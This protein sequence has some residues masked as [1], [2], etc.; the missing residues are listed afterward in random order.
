[1]GDLCD[2]IE[3]DAALGDLSKS[4]RLRGFLGRIMSAAQIDQQSDDL[5]ER[6]A[7][8]IAEVE[9]RVRLADKARWHFRVPTNRR[10]M[11]D[12]LTNLKHLR[13]QERRR[14]LFGMDCI[15]ALRSRHI[16]ELE[17]A[18]ERAPDASV[19][20]RLL[21]ADFCR[22][23]SIIL[24]DGTEVVPYRIRDAARKVRAFK[25]SD[26]G[27]KSSHARL[28]YDEAEL[29]RYVIDMGFRVRCK[30]RDGSRSGLYTARRPNRV[31]EA[32]MRPVSQGGAAR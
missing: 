7:A 14:Y 16:E 32:S 24:A 2:I 31:M 11:E 21:E 5:S 30:S 19:E 13:E 10:C 4:Q 23:F 27:N 8:R 26:E 20:D 25:V 18:L 29:R 1:M 17:S 22:S 6:M 15:L 12:D 3:A 28:V 9:R